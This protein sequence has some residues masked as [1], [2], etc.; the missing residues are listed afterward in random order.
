MFGVLLALCGPVACKNAASSELPQSPLAGVLL[1]DQEGA[2]LQ[3]EAYQ[4]KVLVLNFMF[5]SCPVVCPRQTRGLSEVQRALP[6]EVRDRV[7]FLSISVDP[8]NDTPVAMK[9]FALEQ[10]VTLRG[11]SFA[12]SSAE[13]TRT[14]TNRLGVFDVRQASPAP[15]G[16]TSAVYLFD[17]RG[18]LMQRYAGM[19]SDAPRLAREI[20]Q[21]DKLSRSGA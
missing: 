18:R 6:K 9:R 3:A 5:T 20:Q 21:V 13:G 16:H 10:G 7:R 17:S 15:A 11:W 8:E 2:P 14:L 19:L 4:G 1:T 12:R